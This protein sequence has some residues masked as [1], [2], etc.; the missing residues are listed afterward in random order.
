MKT[1]DLDA[2]DRSRAAVTRG[3]NSYPVK[4]ITPRIA[5]AVDAANHEEDGLTKMRRFYDAAQL[6]VPTM[7]RE[8]IDDL[9]VHQ[10]MAILEVSRAEMNAVEEAAGAETDPNGTGATTASESPAPAPTS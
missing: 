7:P 3:G 1:L 5:S 6:L 8:M 10:I 2:L 9:T 4:Q